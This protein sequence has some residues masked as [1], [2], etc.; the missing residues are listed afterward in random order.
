MVE[1]IRKSTCRIYERMT[2][3]ILTYSIVTII[4]PI[5]TKQTIWYLKIEIPKIFYY[6][7]EH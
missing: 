2:R 1:P 3:P 6:D 5:R 7:I 4:E